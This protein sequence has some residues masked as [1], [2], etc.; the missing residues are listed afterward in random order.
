MSSLMFFRVL[1]GI[2]SEWTLISCQEA[3][4]SVCIRYIDFLAVR[5]IIA[6]N[7]FY[8]VCQDSDEVCLSHDLLEGERQA[9]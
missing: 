8:F 9:T 4:T 5:N 1:L 3:G 6:L 2:D 7:V